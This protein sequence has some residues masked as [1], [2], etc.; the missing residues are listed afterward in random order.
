MGFIVSSNKPITVTE[1]RRTWRVDIE[2]PTDELPTN[3]IYR[4]TVYEHS[5]GRVIS[6]R[7]SQT[8]QVGINDFGALADFAEIPPQYAAALPN[9][10]ALRKMFKLVPLLIS[11]ACDAADRRER[12]K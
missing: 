6:E 12:A 10:E 11:L 4:E 3:N 2:T 8:I 5:D 9:K 1:T 7:D